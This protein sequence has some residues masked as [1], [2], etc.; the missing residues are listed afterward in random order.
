MWLFYLNN[1]EGYLKNEI[2]M[3]GNEG[4]LKLFFLLLLA[5]MILGQYG[6]DEKI[7]MLDS[8]EKCFMDAL[9]PDINDNTITIHDHEII[10]KA[11]MNFELLDS[12]IQQKILNCNLDLS[13]SLK[14]CEMQFGQGQCE[15]Y[16]MMFFQKCAEGFSSVGCCICALKCPEETKPIS[17][18]LLCKKPDVIM[19][20]ISEDKSFCVEGK[21]ECYK[22]NKHYIENCPI[23]Y[24]E[25]GLG[26]CAYDC[27]GGW[28]D[29]GNYCEPPSIYS[30]KG[31]YLWTPGDGQVSNG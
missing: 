18:G 25:V 12:Q 8:S 7:I 20:N 28:R 16:H 30:R 24:N 5:T 1:K 10:S 14:R 15:K 23:G 6:L 3:K 4:I 13:P 21:K 27:P 9:M 26:L 22:H 31:G 29:L 11:L 2:L 19:R 17:Q